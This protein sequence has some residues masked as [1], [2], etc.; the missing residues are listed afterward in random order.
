MI[1]YPLDENGDI[2]AE[3]CDAYDKH[4]VL[5]VKKLMNLS[6]GTMIIAYP[7][8]TI[9]LSIANWPGNGIDGDYHT[10]L[11]ILMQMMMNIILLMEIILNMILMVT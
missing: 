9:P 4:L 1:D 11:L 7:D 8:Y 10:W 5:H 6:H 3:N 2:S